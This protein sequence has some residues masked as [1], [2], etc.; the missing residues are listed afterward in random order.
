[1]STPDGTERAVT[2][3]RELLADLHHGLDA[4]E[5]TDKADALA[6]VYLLAE[7][8][9]A[10]PADLATI[11]GEFK[12]IAQALVEEAPRRRRPRWRSKRHRESSASREL[13]NIGPRELPAGDHGE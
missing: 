9:G 1:V 8:C 6:H 7:G 12:T 2:A 11:R 5:A 10:T 4:K 3:G 13:P